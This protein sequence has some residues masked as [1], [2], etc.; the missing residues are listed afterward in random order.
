MSGIMGFQPLVVVI[1]VIFAVI[2]L[3][4]Y[5]GQKKK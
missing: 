1:M 5:Y 4:G 3:V 2:G